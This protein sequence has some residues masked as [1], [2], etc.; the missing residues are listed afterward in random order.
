MTEILSEENQAKPETL[1]TKKDQESVYS[2]LS[3]VRESYEED[4]SMLADV[5]L[6]SIENNTGTDPEIGKIQKLKSYLEID[7]QAIADTE[8]RMMGLEKRLGY[9]LAQSDLFEDNKN[10]MLVSCSIFYSDRIN[11]LKTALGDQNV[12]D[13]FIRSITEY[14]RA[15]EHD[16]NSKSYVLYDDLKDRQDYMAN[17]QKNRSM[18]HNG[19]IDQI[20]KLNDLCR[21][22]GIKPLTYRN[23]VK[24]SVTNGF[25]NDRQM[26][27]DRI[28]AARYIT[29]VI[30]IA[31]D[32]RFPRP[33]NIRET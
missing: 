30:K 25:L 21:K 20:N 31:H 7:E 8:S 17:C 27:H 29:G 6:Y 2:E 23:F 22:N 11:D 10:D 9:N 26:Y 3:S 19:M 28:T 15:V 24:N 13:D 14:A 16:E 4:A 1:E 18:C 32:G 33:D 5:L 12:D